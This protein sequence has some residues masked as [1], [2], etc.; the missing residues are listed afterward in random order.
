MSQF[1]MQTPTRRRGSTADVYTVLMAAAV[2]FLLIA[3]VVMFLGAAKVGKGG[4]PIG[5]HEPGK[6]ELRAPAAK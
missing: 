1:G 6:V 2:V 4:S 3:T 5:L